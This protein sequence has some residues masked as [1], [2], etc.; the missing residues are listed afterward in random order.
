MKT[1]LQGGD[2]WDEFLLEDY[3]YDSEDEI[4]QNNVKKQELKN[5]KKKLEAIVRD[6]YDSSSEEEGVK[7]FM[8]SIDQ[9]YKPKE[10]DDEDLEVRKVRISPMHC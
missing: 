10:E 7:S 3:D 4:T 6:L 9:K 1:T 8:E 5:N 2:E